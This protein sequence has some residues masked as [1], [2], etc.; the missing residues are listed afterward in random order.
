MGSQ[1]NLVRKGMNLQIAKNALDEQIKAI[2]EELM[3]IMKARAEAEG[4]QSFKFSVEEGVAEYT[5]K[6]SFGFGNDMDKIKEAFGKS[7]H[8]Y[9]S[10]ETVFA[11]KTASIKELLSNGDDPLSKKARKLGTLNQSDSVSLKPN[12]D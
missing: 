12:K 10:E 5:C 1:A 11:P 4:K 8:T 3:P 9:F 6:H 7:F 2:K